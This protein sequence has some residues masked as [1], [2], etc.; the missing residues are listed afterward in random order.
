MQTPSRQATSPALETVLDAGTLAGTWVLDPPKSSVRLR[1]TALWGLIPVTGFFRGVSGGGTISP[2]GQVTGTLTVATASIDTNSTR[3]D[4]H[5]R[6]S[7]F[8]DSATYPDIT[9]T[10]DSVR[11]HG[12]RVAVR[13]ALTVRDSSRTMS[14]DAA[15]VVR[16][17]DEIQL[18]A[19]VETNR[20]D[21]GMIWN[22]MHAV[23]LNNIITVSAVFFKRT[24]V[25]TDD[26][27]GASGTR[28]S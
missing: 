4:K 7:D 8:F 14:F 24:P 12:E 23:S 15:A 21:F 10:L 3:R 5:L 28:E 6:S 18:D 16:G 27:L 20:A 11:P 1:S 2:A 22:P 19:E 25:A 26:V 17:E 9:F 13:G